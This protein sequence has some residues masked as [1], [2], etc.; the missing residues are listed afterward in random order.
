MVPALLLAASSLAAA[1]SRAAA[2]FEGRFFSGSATGSGD[3]LELLDTARRSLGE[4]EGGAADVEIQSMPM[5]YSG[6][7]DGLLEGPTWGAYWTQNSYGTSMT[8]APFLG[9]VALHGMR[10][11]QNW[12]FDNM[13]DGTTN[14]YKGFSAPDGTMCDNG[15]PTG[16]NFKQGDGNVPIHDWTLEET[17]SAVVMQAE[18]LVITR[19]T[20]AIEWN[21][22]RFLRTFNLIEARRDF[23]SGGLLF[24]SGPSSN[25]LAPSFG[26][27]PL[28]NGKHAWSYMTGV[29]VTY[30]A[31]L[32]RAIECAKLVPDAKMPTSAGM[33]SGTQFVQ[34]FEHR[35]AQIRQGL[36]Q[37]L[38]P[39][40][41]Y[42]IRSLD[43]NGTMHGVIG[44][45]RH[46]Y[47]EASPNHDAVAL[48]VVNDTLG[49]KIVDKIK[50]LGKAIRPNTF[51][52]PNTDA[53]G[54]PPERDGPHA[55][56]KKG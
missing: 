8:T 23:A 56:A 25:L 50:S 2:P 45:E 46:G 26:G 55:V 31:G 37:L 53:H 51:I 30:A 42:F 22:P 38:S 40:K 34:L 49:A 17:L 4:P 39:T 44:Q 41:D 24:L 32:I 19:N 33:W 10:E 28:D 48:G 27:W 14:N 6:G 54:K 11:S 21:L 18:L 36:P 5:L 29:A 3:E 7:E 47:F 9:D 15:E 1:G 35:L 52:L 13:A 43:P 20:S 16:C 12:W